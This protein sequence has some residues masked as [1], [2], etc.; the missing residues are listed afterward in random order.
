LAGKILAEL[1]IKSVLMITLTIYKF[2]I[3]GAV[4]WTF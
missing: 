1:E 4:M 2:G 3:K